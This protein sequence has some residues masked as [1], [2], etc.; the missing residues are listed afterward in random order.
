MQILD[1][2]A[3][4]ARAEPTRE[5]VLAVLARLDPPE[6]YL[7]ERDDAPATPVVRRASLA[8]RATGGRGG[9]RASAILGTISLVLILLG[10]PLGMILGE[11]LESEVLMI[12]GTVIC[13]VGSL[14]TAIIALVLAIQNRRDGA[15]A[16]T[17]LVTGIIGVLLSFVG[18]IACIFL[19]L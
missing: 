2:L 16:I 14:A 10:A 6:A 12:L 1:L 18:A 13:A 7:P 15:L 5:D 3:E 17:G 19:L 11:L 4:H 8:P 9:A